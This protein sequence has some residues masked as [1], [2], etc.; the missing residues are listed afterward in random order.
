[1]IWQFIVADSN[2]LRSGDKR[3]HRQVDMIDAVTTLLR[4]QQYVFAATGSENGVGKMVRH[5]SL[6][7]TDIRIDAVNRI[8]GQMQGDNTVAT[9][10]GLEVDVEITAFFI[11]Y[12]VVFII[13]TSTNRL[14]KV[15]L[16]GFVYGQ[17]QLIY[18]VASVSF[19]IKAVP[20]DILTSILDADV[21]MFM[22][23]PY[24]GFVVTCGAFILFVE[25][26]SDSQCQFVNAI[27]M[28]HGFQAIPDDVFTSFQKTDVDVFVTLPYE[29]FIGAGITFVFSIESRINRQGEFIN[30]VAVVNCL[31][32]IPDNVLSSFQKADVDMLVTLPY[33]CL[34]G[35]GA[36]FVFSIESWIDSQSQLIYAVAVVHCFQAIPEG[37]GTFGQKT[38]LH[39]MAF[40]YIFFIIANCSSLR[41]EETG[42][43]GQIQLEDAVTTVCGLQAV[44]NG[45]IASS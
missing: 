6:A 18:A 29:N 25:N 22:T 28:V 37:V 2:G 30:A 36:A 26:R 8:N 21:D 20:N 12:I 45:V 3:S 15:G 7:N 16:L 43:N 38:D 23:L 35:T 33:V 39:I 41:I 24:V 4:V 34:I 14:V 32:A 1:M 27:T 40:P 42:V 31:Q 9:Q 44:P 10:C 17:C 13:V 11:I 5:Q 19:S